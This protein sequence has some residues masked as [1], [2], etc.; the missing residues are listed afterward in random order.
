MTFKAN[1]WVG[2]VGDFLK[3]TNTVGRHTINIEYQNR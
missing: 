3:G 1:K 2:W